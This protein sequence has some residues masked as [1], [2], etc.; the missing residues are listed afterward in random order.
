MTGMNLLKAWYDKV[1]VQGDLNAVAEFFDTEALAS[2]LMSDFAAQLEDFQTLVPAV[3]HALRNITISVEDSMEMGDKVWARMTLHAQ[4]AEDMTPIHI[5][6]Q[7][8]VRLKDSKI[9][10]AH[11]NYDFV[12]YFEQMGNLP[13]DSVALMLAGETLA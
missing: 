1:W 11:N 13:K 5:S 8:M 6:G 12:S 7:V 2:G 4:K 9:I 3:R 10:E